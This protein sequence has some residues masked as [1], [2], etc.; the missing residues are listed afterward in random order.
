MGGRIR[1]IDDEYKFLRSKVFQIRRELKKQGVNFRE[2][3]LVGP[4]LKDDLEWGKMFRRNFV[5]NVNS[6][7]EVVI[8]IW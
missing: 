8:F 1:L 2:I 6:D 7:T 5:E 4:D 3:S